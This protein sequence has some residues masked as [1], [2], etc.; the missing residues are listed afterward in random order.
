MRSL[1]TSIVPTSSPAAPH[2]GKMASARV[3]PNVV[4]YRGSLRTSC[5]ITGAPTA[6]AAP[7]SPC[8]RGNV[9]C[10]GAVGPVHAIAAMCEGLTSYNPTH[11]Y[12]RA[13]GHDLEQPSEV[14]RRFGQKYS[15]AFFVETA[16]PAQVS[17]E[18]AGCDKLCQGSLLE[19]GAVHIEY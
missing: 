5:T 3:D 19:D 6:T 18:I 12:P 4:K 7:L 2:T 13:A 8:V 15:M 14:P 1:S 11:R 9:G 10:R 16:H 17:F